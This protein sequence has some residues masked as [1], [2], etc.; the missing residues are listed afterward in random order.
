MAGE[1][2]GWSTGL[3]SLRPVGFPFG[4]DKSPENKLRLF[5]FPQI[6]IIFEYTSI[7]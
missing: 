5:F 4:R 1:W 7:N 6:C 2:P 3:P